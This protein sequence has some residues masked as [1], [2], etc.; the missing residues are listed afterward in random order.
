M[1]L[2]VKLIGMVILGLLSSV[3]THHKKNYYVRTFDDILGK[4]PDPSATNRLG[5]S[6][7][8]GFFFPVYFALFIVGLVSLIVFLIIGAICGAVAFILIYLT[9]KILP[10]LWLGGIIQSLLMKIG[11]ISPAKEETGFTAPSYNWNAEGGQGK[12]PA[13]CCGGDAGGSCCSD[14]SQPATHKLD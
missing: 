10:N 13:S 1:S 14:A 8:Y 9:E 7:V 12:A 11:I 3:L 4:E 2:I 6:F 5:R